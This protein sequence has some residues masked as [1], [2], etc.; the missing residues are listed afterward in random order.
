M[1]LSGPPP[2]G[3][4]LRALIVAVT[5]ALAFAPFLFPGAKP[6]NVAAK[7]CIYALLGAS[8]DLLLGYAGMVSF[9][10]VM[11]FGVGS[12]GVGLALYGLGPSWGAAALGS[13]GARRS[14]CWRWRSAAVAA[15]AGDLL[16]H[17]DAGGQLRLQCARLAVSS[18]PAARTA[19]R[20]RF[21][22]GCGR[23]SG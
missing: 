3:R 12:Y 2:R 14:T 19:A 9:A 18:S 4:T 21:P 11:F 7:V 23:A 16:H 20:S 17:G 15:R 13:H 1:I 8:Y 22:K 10:H 5:L 6:L